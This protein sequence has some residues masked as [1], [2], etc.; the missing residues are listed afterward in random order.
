[1]PVMTTRRDGWRRSA[2]EI[3]D[4]VALFIGMFPCRRLM[5]GSPC[6]ADESGALD[7]TIFR[8]ARRRLKGCTL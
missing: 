6:G 4:S 5:A 8:T 7:I 3:P 1:M 2:R